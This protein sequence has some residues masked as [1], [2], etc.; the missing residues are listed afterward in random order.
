MKPHGGDNHSV[1][2][3]KGTSGV[4]F[5]IENMG[6]GNSKPKVNLEDLASPI[7]KEMK[8]NYGETIVDVVPEWIE[9]HGFPKRSTF[10]LK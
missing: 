10:N 1:K 7:Y 5:W 9:N 3:L 4:K 8:N 6:S 2:G